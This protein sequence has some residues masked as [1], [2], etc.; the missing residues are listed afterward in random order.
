MI[1]HE[2]LLVSLVKLA[3]NSGPAARGDAWTRTPIILP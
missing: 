2:T 1:E 3:V